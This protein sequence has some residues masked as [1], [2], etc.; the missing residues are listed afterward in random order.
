MAI[1]VD[2]SQNNLDPA[3][4]DTDNALSANQPNFA[5]WAWDSGSTVASSTTCPGSGLDENRGL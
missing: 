2:E 1:G 5:H 3:T 4:F